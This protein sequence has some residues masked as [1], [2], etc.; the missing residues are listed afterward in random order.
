MIEKMLKP[1]EIVYLTTS[2]GEFDN[3]IE[4]LLFRAKEALVFTKKM[5]S[6]DDVIEEV[7][8][9]LDGRQHSRDFDHNLG[10]IINMVK[11]ISI[12]KSAKESGDVNDIVNATKAIIG[13][14]LHAAGFEYELSPEQVSA[15]AHDAKTRTKNANNI[16]NKDAENSRI[17]MRKR[18]K[19]LLADTPGASQ[20]SIANQ[21][22]IES[23][24][25]RNRRSIGISKKYSE[26]HITKYFLN[27]Y[28][29]L[30]K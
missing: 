16:R 25:A 5:D 8:Q 12:Y 9:H 1:V 26:S 22:A 3:N 28:N 15:L 14:A 20:Y 17:C 2:D 6:A 13:F 11:H 30:K 23:K 19:E 4:Y 7:L 18:A 27:N 24:S 10:S 21:L 29:D